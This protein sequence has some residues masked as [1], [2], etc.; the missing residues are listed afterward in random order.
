MGKCG[1]RPVGGDVRE[2]VSPVARYPRTEP[3]QLYRRVP[4]CDF[5]PGTD[6]LFK[7]VQELLDGKTVFDI[8]ILEICYFDII[9]Y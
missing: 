5:L 7:P 6:R 8:R 9:L 3:R 2:T 4:L 1:I